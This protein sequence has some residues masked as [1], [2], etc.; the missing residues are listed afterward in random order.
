MRVVIMQMLLIGIQKL[1]EIL[2]SFSLCTLFMDKHILIL[3]GSQG[4]GEV[5]ETAHHAQDVM[6]G[7]P[8]NSFSFSNQRHYLFPNSLATWQ[9][10][11]Y[12]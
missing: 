2:S 12:S 11:N 1:A 3:G 5:T 7:G 10:S 6:L 4:E 9:R 8:I